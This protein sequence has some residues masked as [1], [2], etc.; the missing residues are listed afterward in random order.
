MYLIHRSYERTTCQAGSASFMVCIKSTIFNDLKAIVISVAREYGLSIEIHDQLV[1]LI[2]FSRLKSTRQL[3]KR[4][5][6]MLITQLK[7]DH[8]RI[9]Q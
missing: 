9:V 1:K 6:N 7:F 8:S 5:V 3:L 4:V 2:I